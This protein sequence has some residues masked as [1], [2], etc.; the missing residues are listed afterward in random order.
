MVMWGGWDSGVTISGRL[1]E[2]TVLLDYGGDIQVKSKGD[3]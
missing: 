1:M 3:R 2:L